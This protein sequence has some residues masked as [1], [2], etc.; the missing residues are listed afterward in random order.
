[1]NANTLLMLLAACIW[2]MALVAVFSLRGRKLSL[3]QYTA[4][5]LLA[6][7]LPVIGPF[8]V[9]WLRPGQRTGSH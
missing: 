7:L 5:G 4:W 6:L 9:V 1:M 3:A 8:L 2:T